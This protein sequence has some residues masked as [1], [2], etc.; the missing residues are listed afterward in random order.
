LSKFE[1]SKFIESLE[2]EFGADVIVQEEDEIVGVIPT[3]SI[4]LD[5]S[6]GIGGIP[7][8]RV[9]TIYGPESSAK[10]S[11]CLSISK[12]AMN[13][14][15]N[16][17]YVDQ[18]NSLD[19]NYA[20]ALIG[21]FDVSK[22]VLVQPETAEQTLEICEKGIQTGDFGLI[23]LDSIGALAPIKEKED[24]FTD[25]NV[26]LIPRLLSKFLR[27]N[28]FAIRKSNTAFIFVNQV[29]ASIGSYIQ[30]LEMPG[31]HALRHFSSV[32]I[33]LT[34]AQQIK[35]VKDKKSDKDDAE[36][37]IGSYSK[38]T[39]K[40]NK[41]APPFRSSTFPLIYGKGIDSTRNLIDFAELLGVVS[42]RGSYYA[43]EGETLGQG[44]NKTLEY[45]DNHKELLDKIQQKVYN[46]TETEK[47]GVLDAEETA[48]S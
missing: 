30:S 41:L 23:I 21:N 45:L 40:K 28:M 47:K 6:L 43:F 32:L 38:F 36:E 11:L 19:H 13:M 14:G 37:I 24:E 10:T 12:T 33:Q 18:E 46:V 48:E 16:V 7:I 3:G 22:F 20:R 15:M 9:T 1:K 29:R 35:V 44:L 31:G 42:K 4:A 5:V 26:A 8:G 34:K 2:E 27:R 25:A 17:L 39:T